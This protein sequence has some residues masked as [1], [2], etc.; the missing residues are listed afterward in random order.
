[1]S[2]ADEYLKEKEQIDDLLQRGFSIVGIREELDGTDVK[3][4]RKGTD[5]EYEEL[6]L[7]TADARKYVSTFIVH[8]FKQLNA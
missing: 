6:R 8:F 7:L 1:M 3:F 5:G 2:A 4:K